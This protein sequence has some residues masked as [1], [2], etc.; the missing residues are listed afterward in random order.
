M[1]GTL[2]ELYIR[3]E[4]QLGKE[5]A[6][7]LVNANRRAY[8]EKEKYAQIW[9]KGGTF[10]IGCH[11]RRYKTPTGKAPNFGGKTWKEDG[12]K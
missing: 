7:I 6:K 8:G 1:G 5:N 10:K 3:L 11:K 12:T 4:E 2:L 9:T